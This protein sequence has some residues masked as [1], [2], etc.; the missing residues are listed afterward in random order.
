MKRNPNSAFA[1][2]L[3]L[4]VALAGCSKKEQPAPRREPHKAV[5]P[6][7][8]AMQPGVPVQAQLSS[9]NKAPT[10]T[11]FTK[12][13]DP[14]KPY[15]IASAQPAVTAA[16]PATA[17]SPS[18]DLL[19]IQSYET[20][21]FKVVGIIA[22]LKE[23]RALVVDPAGKGY[24]VQVGMQ[25]GNANGH[26][27]RITPYGIEVVERYREDTGRVKQRKIVLTL[28]KKR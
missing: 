10:R 2:L 19:P 23:N 7:K 5:G 1:A 28:A 15:V 25:I 14:F 18:T 12:K 6:A 24:V 4:A 17:A 9:A 11:D 16:Q 26:I 27:T 3:L 21:K 20:A 22:G 8:P 13:V